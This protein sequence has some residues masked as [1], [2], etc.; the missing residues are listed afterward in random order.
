MAETG[1]V[2][3]AV[4]V[5]GGVAA[6]D[7]ASLAGS[8]LPIRISIPTGETAV[9]PLSDRQLAAATVDDEPGVF[10]NAFGFG[11][12]TVDGKPKPTLARLASWTNEIKLDGTRL[13]VTVPLENTSRAAKVIALVA[14]GQTVHLLVGEIPVNEKTVSLPVTVDTGEHGVLVLVEGWAGR[15]D[16]VSRS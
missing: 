3:G 9:L 5:T 6:V 12:E 1:H 10:D 8:S 15:L 16:S 4:A 13:T 7:V 11:V 2:V 14:E